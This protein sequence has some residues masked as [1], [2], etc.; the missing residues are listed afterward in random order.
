MKLDDKNVT[1]KMG[2]A[3]FQNCAH[4]SKMIS[5]HHHWHLLRTYFFKLCTESH[6]A[7]PFSFLLKGWYLLSSSLSSVSSDWKRKGRDF[8]SVSN[9][10]E[11]D[12]WTCNS[13]NWRHQMD[14]RSHQALVLGSQRTG[15]LFNSLTT[16]VC[17]L[18]NSHSLFHKLVL[19]A[20]YYMHGKWNAA[21]VLKAK[22]KLKG[23]SLK[24]QTL[25]VCIILITLQLSE[26]L[27]IW[28]PDQEEMDKKDQ[29]IEV[30]NY[31]ILRNVWDNFKSLYILGLSKGGISSIQPKKQQKP[32]D[33]FQNPKSVKKQGFLRQEQN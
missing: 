9:L 31:G 7:T 14:H 5:T 8:I 3:G 2:P 6:K 26:S 20:V 19:V 33:H 28:P 10:T 15:A 23:W 24:I 17:G 1:T 27:S 11:H 13:R 32:S 21:S 30:A 12:I 25:P 22:L 29:L 4:L 16:A 18:R